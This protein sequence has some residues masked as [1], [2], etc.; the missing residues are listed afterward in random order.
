MGDTEN[1]R[2]NRGSASARREGAQNKQVE[3]FSVRGKLS[4][5][6]ENVAYTDNK[7]S[8]GRL[9]GGKDEERQSEHGHTRCSSAAHRQPTEEWWAAEPSVGRV[10]NGIPKRV[11]RL[12][13]LGN[14]IVPQIAMQIGLCIKQVNEQNES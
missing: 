12:K 14:A 10:A 1:D 11:D 2:C 5:S 9:S 8:Q 3:Q 13:G 4:R 6:S 7:R